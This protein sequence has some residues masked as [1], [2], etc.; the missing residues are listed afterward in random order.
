MR[1]SEARASRH[2]FAPQYISLAR[3]DGGDVE[4]R[5]KGDDEE[6]AQHL[7]QLPEG[8][9]EGRQ[10]QKWWACLLG[11]TH[12]QGSGR[13]PATVMGK[14]TGGG[15]AGARQRALLPEQRGHVDAAE[16]PPADV[17][18]LVQLPELLCRLALRVYLRGKDN[19]V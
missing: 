13:R 6:Q 5:A 17:E 4:A 2:P 15:E 10:A 11:G 19:G 1:A 14:R 8:Q 3:L 18:H 12:G 7:W 16:A 9:H